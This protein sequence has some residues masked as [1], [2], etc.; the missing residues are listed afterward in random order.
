[1][2]HDAFAQ[3][4][5]FAPFD[6]LRVDERIFDP[7]KALKPFDHGFNWSSLLKSPKMDDPNDMRAGFDDDDDD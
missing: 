1:L 6:L 2:P 4:A 5:D 7:V 3:E